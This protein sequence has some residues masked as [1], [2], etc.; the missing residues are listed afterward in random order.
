[1]TLIKKPYCAAMAGLFLLLPTMACGQ[2]VPQAAQGD[3]A[4]AQTGRGLTLQAFTAKRERRMLAAD[5]DGDGKVSKAEFLAAA[6]KG[7]GDPERRFAKLD[8]NGDGFIDRQEIA[9]MSARRFARLDT[10]GDGVLSAAERSAARA[11][12]RAATP[13]E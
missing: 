5:T 1:M 10:N 13:E 12:K 7:K 9:A 3:A 11:L 2:V 6:T 8:R 4:T